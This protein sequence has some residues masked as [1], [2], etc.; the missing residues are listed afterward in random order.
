[1]KKP[2]AGHTSI[3]WNEAVYI[4][5]GAYD[6]SGS[7]SADDKTKIEIWN[8]KDSPNQFKATENWPVLFNWQRPHLF[9]VPDSFFPDN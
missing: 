3:Y 1:M 9:I 7:K 6:G 8:I 4:I 5:G 2:R